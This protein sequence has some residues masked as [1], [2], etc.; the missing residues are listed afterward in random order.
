MAVRRETAVTRGANRRPAGRNDIPGGVNVRVVVAVLALLIVAVAV[1]HLMDDPE[2]PESEPESTSGPAGVVLELPPAGQPPTP[3]RPDGESATAPVPPQAAPSAEPP[4]PPL[5]VGLDESDRPL[6]ETLSALFGPSME[7]LLR[8]PEL[9]RKSVIVLDNL[10][11]R[12]LPVKYLPLRPP[13]PPFRVQEREDGERLFLDPANY[14]RYR[15]YVDL[16]SAVDMEA[17][18]R[19]IARFAPLLQAAYEELGY[20]DRRFETR[21]LAV[22]DDLLQAPEIEG[23]IELVQPAVYYKYADPELEALSAGQKLMLRMGPENARQV[24]AL[25]QRLRRSLVERLP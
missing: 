15:P 22:I 18:A 19:Q 24:K 17:L 10:T 3:V 20:P 6:R 7:A 5:E 21:L 9:L 13:P 16:L 14:A 2:T 23:P 1:Y 25:L 4:L 12:R 11:T 8:G